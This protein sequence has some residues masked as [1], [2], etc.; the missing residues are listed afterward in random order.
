MTGS[1]MGGPTTGTR[2][3]LYDADCGFCTVAAGWLGPLGCEVQT[4]PWQSWPGLAEHGI[5]PEAAAGALHMVHG[6]RVLIGHEAVAGA[7]RHSRWSVVRLAGRL[8]GSRAL[9]PVAS[10]VYA[11]VA[12]NRQRLPG[13]TDACRM[14]QTPVEGPTRP[15]GKIRS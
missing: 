15:P 2:V 5:T 11:V 1:S 14:E 3:V 7:L 4:I 13:G 8:I 6:D 12:A 9:R 10:R